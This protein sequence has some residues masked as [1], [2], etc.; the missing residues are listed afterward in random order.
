MQ[1]RD[2]YKELINTNMNSI[3]EIE[4]PDLDKVKMANGNIVKIDKAIKVTFKL[5]TQTFTEDFLV[6]IVTTPVILGN[7][8]FV[9]HKVSICPGQSYI[10]FPDQTLQ[11]NEIKPEKQPR[12]VVK[13]KKFG[14]YTQKKQ[15]LQPNQQAVLECKLYDKLESFADLC[16]VI[17]PNETFEKDSEIILTSS[18]S[19]VA[20]N[21]ILYIF[22]LNITDHPIT[23]NKGEETAKFSFLTSDQAENLL[24][25]DPQ[26]INKLQ[27]IEKLD[28][29][30]NLQ[31]KITFLSKFPWEKSAL[32]DE[33]K[34]VVGEL[35]VEF[36]D[37]FA[38][39]RF[40]SGY[41]TDLKIKLT[42]ERSIPI[43]E[44]GPPTPVHLR[45]ELQVELALMHYYGL[46]TTLSQSRYS[47]PLFAQR[48]NSERL[49][50]LIDLRKVNHLLK[51]D[52][53]NTNF[54]ISNMSVAIN[55]F[56]G[57]KLFTKLDCSQA[58][59][60]VQMADDVSVQLLAFN[61]LRE[62]MHINVS[63]KD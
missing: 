52:Y 28:P 23:I 61:L 2:F 10:K 3:T 62:L 31:D 47:S 17:I 35:L 39:H 9:K 41:N 21:N 14:I 33:Q 30:G 27:E 46:I 19:K 36:S 55:Y 12:R 37:I 59:N 1:S 38:K 29:R 58:Y 53:V 42:P 51:N 32:N 54:P 16:R 43:Y 57:K 11:I 56:A 44:Q 18:L 50:L 34:A 63:L 24:E 6:L 26:L 40:D 20:E 8:F 45:N 15:V 4:K 22:V 5:G 25:V 60:C 13:R 49:R 48:K 7:P